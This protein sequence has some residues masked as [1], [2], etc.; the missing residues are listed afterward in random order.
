MENTA[1]VQNSAPTYKVYK[2]KGIWAGS[3]LGGPLVA[4]YLIAENFKAFG[5]KNKAR[6]TWI[7]TVVSTIVLFALLL[8]VPFISKLPAPLF[9]L[10]YT[11]IAYALVIRYQKQKIDAHIQA[12][13]QTFK[14]YRILGVG[15]IGCI[16]TIIPLAIT[17]YLTDPSMSYTTKAYGPAKNE[18]LYN[19][20]SI[21]DSE[22]DKMADALTKVGLFGQSQEVSVIMKIEDNGYLLEM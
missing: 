9:P 2:E 3:F 15:V 16:I 11:A 20:K 8:F 21:S 1:T 22:A 10:V 13:G 4:G 6:N 19:K 17:L 18:L 12:G 14:W 5:D 7:I